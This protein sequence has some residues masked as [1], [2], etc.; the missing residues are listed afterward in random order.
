MKKFAKNLKRY[1]VARGL[2]QRQL[3]D[4]VK[5]KSATISNYENNVS[6]PDLDKISEISNILEVSVDD[7]LTG[8]DEVSIVQ[9]NKNSNYSTN[10]INSGVN[11]ESEKYKEIIKLKDQLIDSQKREIDLLRKIIDKG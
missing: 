7:L 10:A 4:I 6:L 1:R 8:G 11:E 5:V 9:K 2:T 3:A